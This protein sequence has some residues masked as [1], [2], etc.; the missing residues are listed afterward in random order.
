LLGV[1][2]QYPDQDTMIAFCRKL[3]AVQK[4]TPEQTQ[5]AIEKY[6]GRESGPD[7]VRMSW[8][9]RYATAVKAA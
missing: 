3:F 7:G 1:P 5:E 8:Q 6:L 2:W 9:L 4:A